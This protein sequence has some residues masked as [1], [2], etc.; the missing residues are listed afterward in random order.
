[1]IR[2]NGKMILGVDLGNYNIKTEHLCFPSAYV[3][4]AGDGNN[5]SHTLRYNG[6]YYALGGKRVAQRDDK[7]SMNDD[8]LILTQFAIARELHANG[9]GP[10][11][12]EIYLATALPPAYMNNKAMRTGLKQFF[13]R[14]MEFFYNG[15]RYRVNIV[16]VYVC[17]QGVSALYANVQTERMGGQGLEIACR[18]PMAALAK[19]GMAVLVDIGGGTVDPVVLQY[20]VP[21]P[22]E[23]EHP[24]RGTIWTYNSIRRDIKAKTGADVPE[25]AVNLY[26]NGENIRMDETSAGIIREHIDH[27][28]NRLLMELQEKG[29]PFATAYTLV[30]GGG[31]KFVRDAWKQLDTFA[32]LDF[33]PEIR[34]TAMG[35][36]VIAQ[37]MMLREEQKPESRVS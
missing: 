21:Q 32:V 9:L 8:F 13:R 22:F 27:Y 1:M 33:L 5:Y 12:Y 34:A 36:E 16:R 10:G 18:S 37:R 35:C 14:Q 3:E 4:L 11:S 24:A 31:A 7:A 30:Q 20:G 29:L 6:R 28:A 26:L 2:H 25:E 23:D 15:Q 19:E 17:P